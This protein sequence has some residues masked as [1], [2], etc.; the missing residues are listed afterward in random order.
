M[1]DLVKQELWDKSS[2][3]MK[4]AEARQVASSLSVILRKFDEE[5][6]T[7]FDDAGL[8]TP[9]NES[10]DDDGFATPTNEMQG[11]EAG[12]RQSFFDATE[13]RMNLELMQAISRSQ[14]RCLALWDNNAE[15]HLKNYE[16]QSLVVRSKNGEIQWSKSQLD[17]YGRLAEWREGVAARE[18]YSGGF[19]CPLGLLANVALRRP[20][21]ET[22]LKKLQFHLPELFSATTNY[23]DEIFQLVRQSRRA[24]GL[25]EDDSSIVPSYFD[26]L[27][28]ER[29]GNFGS[30]SLLSELIEKIGGPVTVWVVTCVAAIAITALATRKRR[31]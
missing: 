19:V 10:E 15:P 24:D 21:S 28:R 13:L 31:N 11:G 2:Q 18:E 3:P 27:E 5:D 23:M 16:F 30:R 14:S 9:T 7:S 29:T 25:E 1:R 20:T 26:Y 17:L 4:D 8:A 6:E 12:V 22:G